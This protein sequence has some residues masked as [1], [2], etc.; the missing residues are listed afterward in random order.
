MAESC[1]LMFAEKKALGDG[2]FEDSA[3]KIDYVPFCK[4]G[5]DLEKLQRL[6]EEKEPKE[7]GETLLL[8]NCLHSS[9]FGTEK[10]SETGFQSKQT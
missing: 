8:T 9:F 5:F 2:S 3:F 10:Y 4:K 1:Y 6:L 7:P